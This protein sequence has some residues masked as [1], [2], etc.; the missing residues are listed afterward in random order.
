[1][2]E[3]AISHRARVSIHAPAPLAEAARQERG[4]QKYKR[5]RLRGFGQLIRSFSFN[6]YGYSPQMIEKPDTNPL[7]LAP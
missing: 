5:L 4:P 7:C 1:M 2:K 3:L 6:S